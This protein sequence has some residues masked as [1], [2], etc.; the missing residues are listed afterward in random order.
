MRPSLRLWITRSPQAPAIDTARD[1]RHAVS[2]TRPK[3]RLA[4]RQLV[5][6]GQERRERKWPAR[7]G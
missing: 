6:A 5:I 4:D 2:D 7:R 3:A 1:A